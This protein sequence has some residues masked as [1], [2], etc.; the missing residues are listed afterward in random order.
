M[1]RPGDEAERYEEGLEQ[2][3][4]RY[5]DMLF[6]L[7]LVILGTRQEAEDAV[8]ET[9]IKYLKKRP[10]FNEAEHEKAW[11]M[12]VASNK[13]K[14][15]LRFNSRHAHADIDQMKEYLPYEQEKST[16]IL[17]EVMKLKPKYRQIVVLHHVEGYKV[18]EISEILGITA[19]AVKKRLQYAR[20]ILRIRIK[21]DGGYNE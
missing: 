19:S 14:D 12:R 18:K 9:F 16:G 2:V 17:E 4:E 15:I 8:Q 7:C 13:C 5:G 6:R 10:S 11:L 1:V 3:F 20:D 21:A